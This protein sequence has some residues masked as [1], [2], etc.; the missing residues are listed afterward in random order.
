MQLYVWSGSR[1][2]SP[3]KMCISV[4]VVL[5]EDLLL[6]MGLIEQEEEKSRLF[7]PESFGRKSFS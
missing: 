6:M 4:G 1:F 2:V 7:L 5:S 3:G